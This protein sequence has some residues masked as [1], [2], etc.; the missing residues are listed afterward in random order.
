MSFRRSYTP[1]SGVP[2]TW[3]HLLLYTEWRQRHPAYNPAHNV[4]INPLCCAI[5][6]SF[7]PAKSLACS[8]I[9]FVSDFCST[10]KRTAT[11]RYNSSSRVVTGRA[12]TAE[13]V[14]TYR[15]AQKS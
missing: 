11:Q 14:H 10:K 15:V 8:A 5:Y 4:S 7:L 2:P 9:T 13:S 3:W 1:A 12:A 6:T